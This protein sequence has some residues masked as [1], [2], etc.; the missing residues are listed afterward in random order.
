MA[1]VDITISTSGS[2]SGQL[3]DALN[4]SISPQP[5]TGKNLMVGASGSQNLIARSVYANQLASAGLNALRNTFNFAKSNYGNFTGDYVGQ[6]KIDNAFS[7]ANTFVSLGSS[8]FNG[9]MAGGI[10]G[11]V[12]GAVVGAVSMGVTAWQSGVEYK[13]SIIKA[14]DSAFFN[15]QRIGNVLRNGSR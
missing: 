14:N 6:Q 7:V 15:S 4:G 9:A 3:P 1:R 11:A 12:V 10:P 13:T 5:Q 2:S 8:I